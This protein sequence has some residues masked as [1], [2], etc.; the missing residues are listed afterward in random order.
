MVH[1]IEQ[2]LLPSESSRGDDLIDLVDRRPASEPIWRSGSENGLEIMAVAKSVLAL[3]DVSLWVINQT[4]VVSKF[5]GVS[6]DSVERQAIELFPSLEQE[7]SLSGSNK[8]NRRWNQ[9]L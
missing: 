5:L 1:L 2:E 7:I 8:E 3:S 9:E 4:L 6:F